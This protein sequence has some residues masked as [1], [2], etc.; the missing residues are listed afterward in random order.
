MG[1]GLLNH[2]VHYRGDAKQTLL[3]VVLGYL[4][5]ADGIGTELPV[6]QTFNYF[7]LVAT[8]VWEQLLHIHL[9]DATAPLVR[10]NLSVGSVKVVGSQDVLK[11]PV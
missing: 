11:H 5:P 7:H 9:V 6:Q 8:Q 3:P 1:D 2:P 10:L 4:H